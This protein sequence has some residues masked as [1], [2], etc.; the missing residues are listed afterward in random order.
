M[1]KLLKGITVFGT[2]MGT[3]L[4][5]HL[6]GCSIFPVAEDNTLKA[7]DWYPIVGLLLCSL[8]T[9][10]VVKKHPSGNKRS[11]AEKIQHPTEQN[12]A[13]HQYYHEDFAEQK[14]G[15]YTKP[16]LTIKQSYSPK[17]FEVVFFRKHQL[18]S[19]AKTYM[20][21]L[22][23]VQLGKLR[24]GGTLSAKTTAGTHRVEFKGY[25]KMETSFDFTIPED[26][27]RTNIF[28]HI[29]LKTGKIFVADIVTNNPQ[30][31]QTSAL[32]KPKTAPIRHSPR[33]PSMAHIDKMEGHEFEQFTA[34]LLRKLGYE[35]VEVTPGS[36]DQGVDVIAVKNGKR[37]AIQCKRYAQKLGNKPV[38]E[39]FAGK[40]IYGCSIAVV[41]TNN[42]FT[43]GAKEAAKATGVELWDRDTLRRLMDYANYKAIV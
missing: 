19:S 17:N 21:F 10:L 41:L 6:I 7:P 4:V 35:R 22:D 3:F 30:H 24:N 43:E 36:G 33:A 8:M 42:Y 34:D 28:T 1:N 12:Q 11:R 32:S 31:G 18:Q 39:V 23:G 15:F 37:Y 26:Q 40:T 2:F 25:F 14:P 9:Y 20:V 29:S 16:D 5:Y 27:K 13:S 38:Q